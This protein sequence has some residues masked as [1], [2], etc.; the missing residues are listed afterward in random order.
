[1]YDEDDSPEYGLELFYENYGKKKI[2]IEI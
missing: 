1:V 2:V